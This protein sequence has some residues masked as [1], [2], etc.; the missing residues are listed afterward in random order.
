M[1]FLS[2]KICTIITNYDCC[3]SASALKIQFSRYLP[4][5]LIDASSPIQPDAADIIIE[6]TYYPGLWNAA[7]SH[8]IENNFEWIFF[9]ASD[10]EVTDVELLCFLVCEAAEDDNIGIYTPSLSAGSRVAF[11][12]LFHRDSNSIRKT[13]TVEGFCFL[14]RVDILKNLFPIDPNNKSGWGVDVRSSYEAYQR[15]KLVVADDRI[16]IFHPAA[17]LG[18]K[19]D[20]SVATKESV[21]YLGPSIL[22]WYQNFSTESQNEESEV[23]QSPTTTLDLGCGQAAKNPFGA[24]YAYGIDIIGNPLRRIRQSDLNVSGIP[25]P[26]NFF[27]FITAYDFIAHVSRVV[28]C[29]SRRFS[30]I[31]LMNEI[32]RVI[33]PGGIFLSVT[34]AFPHS[35][36]FRDPTHVNH[37]T[38]ETFPLYF[39]RDNLWAEMY[40]FTGDF[41]LLSQEWDEGKLKT[42]I[43]ALK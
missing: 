39:C 10:V 19:I 38:E 35:Y 29:P 30:F 21:N 33:R 18:H 13:C 14:A 28:Y 6:N 20:S 12:D 43:R 1:S 11:S 5:V 17:R 40:G 15:G 8:C 16:Q 34:P 31:E 22:A 9:I 32:Y 27:N 3:E 36:S 41:E 4:T 23:Y 25:F 24:D 37:I 42:A 26:D 2:N 7:V